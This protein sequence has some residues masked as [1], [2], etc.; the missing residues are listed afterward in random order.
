MIATDK[1]SDRIA[2][3][4][5][6]ARV[7]PAAARLGVMVATA[8]PPGQ[9]VCPDRPDLWWDA[10]ANADRAVTFALVPD[11]LSPPQ[12]AHP[13]PDLP[14]TSL[15]PRFTTW[16]LHWSCGHGLIGELLTVTCQLALKLRQLLASR[17]YLPVEFG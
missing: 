13:A 9:R 17:L 3:L 14:R 1:T 8:G 16:R 6:Q 4:A 12:P 10:L 11:H 5:G 15:R 2:S 7:S